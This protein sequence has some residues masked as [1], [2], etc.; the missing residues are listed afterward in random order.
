MRTR[1]E[2]RGWRLRWLLG[3]GWCLAWRPLWPAAAF[4][5]DTLMRTS[6]DLADRARGRA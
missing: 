6:R 4:A 1:C 2:E 5:A 3:A